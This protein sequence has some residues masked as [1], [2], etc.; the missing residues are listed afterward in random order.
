MELLDKIEIESTDKNNKCVIIY[1]GINLSDTMAY[2]WLMFNVSF[3]KNK[4]EYCYTYKKINTLINDWNEFD[5]LICELNEW[6]KHCNMDKI[7]KIFNETINDSEI[8]TSLK[9]SYTYLF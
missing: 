5:W 2:K 8:I 4:K 3:G 9:W 6:V 7:I 1:V